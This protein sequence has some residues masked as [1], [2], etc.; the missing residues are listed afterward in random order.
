MCYSGS[1]STMVSIDRQ[2]R[3]RAQQT[4]NQNKYSCILY[5]NPGGNKIQKDTIDINK[6]KVFIFSFI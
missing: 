3:Q 1:H 6:K 4:H 2:Q 5:C